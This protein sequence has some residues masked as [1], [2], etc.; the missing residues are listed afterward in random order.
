MLL[1]AKLKVEDKYSVVRG[2]RSYKLLKA[3]NVMFGGKLRGKKCNKNMH[4]HARQA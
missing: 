3:R 4:M 1:V 2:K